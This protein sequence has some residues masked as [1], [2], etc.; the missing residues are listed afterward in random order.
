MYKALL[1]TGTKILRSTIQINWVDTLKTKQKNLRCV[2]CVEQHHLPLHSLTPTCH[3]HFSQMKTSQARTGLV[4]GGLQGVVISF[5]TGFRVIGSFTEERT[6]KDV[7]SGQSDQRMRA[8][9]DMFVLSWPQLTP[10]KGTRQKWVCEN[11]KGALQNPCCCCCWW[12]PLAL[13]NIYQTGDAVLY[14]KTILV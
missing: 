13:C 6:R 10:S 7:R 14:K 5:G 2:H 3:K 1:Q 4:C 11:L 9:F 12:H 8:D